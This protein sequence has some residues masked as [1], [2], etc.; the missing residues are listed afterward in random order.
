M[1]STA[2]RTV[3]A[4]A[5]V[6]AFAAAAHSQQPKTAPRAQPLLVMDAH[7]DPLPRVLD[8]GDD[9]GDES[10]GGQVDIPKL[11]RGGVNIVWFALWVDPRK[12]QGPAAT[13]RAADLLA[14]FRRQVRRH[15]DDMVECRTAA[16]C[17][18]AAASGKIAA[19]V[20]IEGGIA[21]NDDLRAIQQ[22]CD[23]GARRMVLT[24]RGNL[25]WAG[26]SQSEDPSRGLSDFGRS[27]VR[28]MNRLGMVVDL[29]HVSDR[30]F[31][32]AIAVSRLPVIV[33]HSNAR[34][35]APHPRNVTDDMLRTL[36]DNGGVIGV[37]FFQ[38]YLKPDPAE[39]WF[40]RSGTG[41][42]KDVL[43]QTDH[44][45][46]VAGIDHVGIGS[47]LDG[48]IRPARGL[49]TAAKMPALFEGLRSR[50]YSESDI[51]KIAGENFLRVLEANERGAGRGP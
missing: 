12:F 34:A 10:A 13:Q 38:T 15:G 33:S 49:E 43:D 9:L 29:S 39:G 41:T 3:A 19:L 4:L 5:A 36:R 37:N 31:Y 50:G 6:L 18:G 44:M 2:R 40:A 45:V 42:L 27:V 30:T 48:D 35:L 21:I 1:R 20:G 14:A 46:R 11:R 22:F 8:R 25:A 51:R 28:E 32:D 26:S 23:A 17:R 7:V 16:Q 47:D 24:W